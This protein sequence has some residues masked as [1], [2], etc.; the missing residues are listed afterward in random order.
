MRTKLTP[1]F[2]AK[3]TAAGKHQMVYWDAAMAGFGLMVT[4]AGH[5]SF[6]V[7]YRANGKSRRATIKFGP[8]LEA[9]RR[10][11]RAIQGSVARGGDPVGEKRAARHAAGTTLKAVVEAY[12]DAEGDKLRS[13]A[14][15]R[16]V[17]NRLVFP[18]PLGDRPIGEIRRGDIVALL[19]TVRKA[20]G[21]RMAASVLAFTRRVMSWHAVRDETFHSPIVRGMEPSKAVRRDRILTDDE[22]R[23]LWKATNQDH[24]YSRMVRFILL[25]ATRRDEA[26]E[27]RWQEV[28]GDTWIIPSARYKTGIEIELPLSGS[29]RAVLTS[30]PRIGTEGWVFTLGGKTRIG[31]LAKHKADLDARMLAELRK[32]AEERGEDAGAL[33][34]PNWVVHDLRRTARS[35]MSRAGVPTDHAERCIGHVIGGVRGTYDRHE[36][37]RE[38]REAFEAL[39]SQIERILNPAD[40]VVPLRAGKAG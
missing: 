14:T 2:I 1:A 22:I 3:A 17:F 16:S 23:A 35:L 20:N 7:Q 34:L 10:E 31:G 12:F 26:A 25:T 24:P 19:D 29:A 39:A 4:P 28:Q 6:V 8:G 18:T 38:K 21:P 9:A 30:M 13:A 40:N 33:T 36:Y 5:K 11:A 32:A 27:L 15:Q 37:A